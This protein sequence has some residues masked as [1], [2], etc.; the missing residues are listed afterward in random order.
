MT[1]GSILAP[2]D[3][4][5]LNWILTPALDIV[6]KGDPGMPALLVDRDL[7]GRE[8]C[9]RKGPDGYGDVSFIPFLDVEDRRP[10]CGA[11]GEPEPCALVSDPNELRA[12]ALDGNGF[13]GKGG[14]R[15][16][17]TA[18]SALASVAVADSDVERI[19][20][21]FRSKLT[22]TARCGANCHGNS[23]RV[24]CRGP[25][26][27]RPVRVVASLRLPAPASVSC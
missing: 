23:R 6:G 8:M 26:T 20:A 19:S 3:G 9:V 21:Y 25:V 11:E 24:I 16:K 27:E 4:A 12:S 5:G 17:D 14:L 2:T 15:A 1:Y 13:A 7:W 10:A 22:T 18:G